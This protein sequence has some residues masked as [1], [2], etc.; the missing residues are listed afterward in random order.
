MKH[1]S[2]T[3]TVEKRWDVKWKIDFRV[4]WNVVRQQKYVD[5]ISRPLWRYWFSL[6]FFCPGSERMGN[7]KERDWTIERWWKSLCVRGQKESQKNTLLSLYQYHCVCVWYSIY[8][9]CLFFQQLNKVDSLSLEDLRVLKFNC[10]FG[11]GCWDW[12]RRPSR[13]KRRSLLLL[14]RYRRRF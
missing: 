13:I 10:L 12:S 6:L 11:G 3:H 14:R 5:D 7:V 8:F 4:D 1:K 2:T 9:C